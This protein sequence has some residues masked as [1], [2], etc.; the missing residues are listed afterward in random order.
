MDPAAARRALP[1]GGGP[2]LE[3][4]IPICAEA[5]SQLTS[6]RPNGELPAPRGPGTGVCARGAHRRGRSC[7]SWTPPVFSESTTARSSRLALRRGHR[8]HRGPGRAPSN[9]DGTGGRT[10][11]TQPPAHRGGT[12]GLTPRPRH[13]RGGF[14]GRSRHSRAAATGRARGLCPSQAAARQAG[15]TASRPWKASRWRRPRKPVATPATS[16]RLQ[17]EL[18]PEL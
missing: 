5:S 7:E 11:A 18:P 12:R 16:S 17:T 1:T 6:R 15:R 14:T 8:K 10:A 9:E 3:R 4:G 13:H 2:A